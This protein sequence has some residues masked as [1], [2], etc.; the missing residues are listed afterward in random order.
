MSAQ[1]W[2]NE[3]QSL[4]QDGLWDGNGVDMACLYTVYLPIIN[5]DLNR[6]MEQ[7]NSHGIRKQMRNG[8]RPIRP[9]G[10]PEDIYAMPDL[11][12]GALKGLIVNDIDVRHAMLHARID[13]LDLDDP[14]PADMNALI[15]HWMSL[16]RVVVTVQNARTVYCQLRQMLTEHM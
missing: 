12:G 7:H 5:D 10:V 16:N 4:M 3:L 14:V 13:A 8:R 11:Y 1:Y 2:M 15:S 9:S 6:V